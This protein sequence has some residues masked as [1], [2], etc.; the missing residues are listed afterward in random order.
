MPVL[1]GFPDPAPHLSVAR[2]RLDAAAHNRLLFD[3]SVQ[4]LGFVVWSLELEV[5]DLGFRV[6]GLGFRVYGLG[7]RVRV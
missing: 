2:L 6:R 4:G 3:C 1:Y 7:F 5:L